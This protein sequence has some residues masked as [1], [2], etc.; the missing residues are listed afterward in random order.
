VAATR[1]LASELGVAMRTVQWWQKEGGEARSVACSTPGL[2]I[3][4]QG[5]ATAQQRASNARAFRERVQEQGLDVGAC[6]V[7]VLVYNEERARPR[8]IGDMHIDG[9]ALT[10]ALDA[11]EVGDAAGAGAAFGNAWLETYGL[12]VDAEV[13]DVVRGIRAW[14]M[15]VRGGMSARWCIWPRRTGADGP[16]LSHLALPLERCQCIARGCR[17]LLIVPDQAQHVEEALC[18]VVDRLITRVVRVLVQLSGSLVKV[19][20]NFRV[21][22]TNV[23]R[24]AA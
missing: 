18:G 16:T 7:M 6:R 12:D 9:D 1:A 5:I 20:R 14:V 15:P 19:R 17:V 2:R 22:T 4:V 10:E 24:L 3:S 8:S 21:R 23:H 13:T 11:L